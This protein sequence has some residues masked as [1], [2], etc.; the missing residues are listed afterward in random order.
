VFVTRLPSEKYRP[1]CLNG[2]PKSGPQIHIW[3]A[4]GRH[5]IASLKRL[6]G[7]L[8]AT[9]YQISGYGGPRRSTRWLGAFVDLPTGPGPRPQ[10]SFY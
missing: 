1:Y 4:I 6:I 3:G 8:N 7:N 9:Q 5:Q 10:R 2:T